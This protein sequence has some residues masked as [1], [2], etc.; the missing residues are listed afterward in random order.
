VNKTDSAIR[1]VHM[2][3]GIVV[4]CQ[5]ERSQHSNATRR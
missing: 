1:I 2:P 3:S 4:A 5:A